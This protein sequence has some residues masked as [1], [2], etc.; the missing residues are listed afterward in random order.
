MGITKEERG[1]NPLNGFM[2][3]LSNPIGE[4]RTKMG[5]KSYAAAD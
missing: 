3:L 2:F 1:V 4:Q 5:E